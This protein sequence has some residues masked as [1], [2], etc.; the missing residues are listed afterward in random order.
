MARTRATRTPLSRGCENG[1]GPLRVRQRCRTPRA[2]AARVVP[3][4][5]PSNG[6]IPYEIEAHAPGG[7]GRDGCWMGTMRNPTLSMTALEQVAGGGDGV[8]SSLDSGSIAS[9]GSS[10]TY[11]SGGLPS[12]GSSPGYYDPV[13]DYAR[14][15][16]YDLPWDDLYGGLGSLYGH[17]TP[18]ATYTPLEF[19]TYNEPSWP[20]S[21]PPIEELMAEPPPPAPEV[22]QAAPEETSAPAMAEPPPAPEAAPEGTSAPAPASA[23][24]N[25]LGDGSDADASDAPQTGAFGQ[26]TAPP[27]PANVVGR[28]NQTFD[29]GTGFG[30]TTYDDGLVVT[31]STETDVQTFDDGSRFFGRHEEYNSAGSEAPSTTYDT[32]SAMDSLESR[33]RD[34]PFFDHPATGSPTDVQT[35]VDVLQNHRSDLLPGEIEVLNDYVNGAFTGSEPPLFQGFPATPRDYPTVKPDSSTG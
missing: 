18:A 29:D 20:T 13:Y 22:A 26:A 34:Q 28:T 25:D 30:T 16:T 14:D 32:T 7:H 10:Y 12:Y 17:G 35:A 23:W 21:P 8:S 33:L 9:S 2:P 31:H 6:E 3:P 27:P 19:P 4:R 24:G 15:T 1:P 5:C 11:S